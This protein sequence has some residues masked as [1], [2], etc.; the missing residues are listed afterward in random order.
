M[1]KLQVTIKEY[2]QQRL[3]DQSGIN[4][5]TISLVATGKQDFSKKAAIKVAATLNISILEAMGL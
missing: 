5:S 3:A 1:K 2:G 4:K